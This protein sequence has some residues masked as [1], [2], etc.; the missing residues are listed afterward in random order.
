MKKTLEKGN[1]YDMWIQSGR[2]K[3]IKHCFYPGCKS[4]RII[5]SHVFQNNG[6]LT[7][8]SENGDV[9]MPKQKNGDVI[10]KLVK[11]GRKMATVFPGFCNEH[12]KKVF[13]PIEDAD[14]KITP[15]TVF[16]FSY[17]T[18]ASQFQA[19]MEF[20][21]RFN[22]LSD[23]LG[24]TTNID[25]LDGFKSSINDFNHDKKFFD[26]YLLNGK[27]PPL[28]YISWVIRQ[29]I[30]FAVSGFNAPYADFE[31]KKIQNSTDKI[32]HHMFYTILPYKGNCV[33]LISWLKTDDRMF[34]SY[35]N[36]LRHLTLLERK[37][38]LSNMAISISDDL[39]LSP[40]LVEQL[41]T[42]QI[43]QI[44]GDYGSIG[45]LSEIMSER[46]SSAHQL[47]N[48]GLNLFDY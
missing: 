16:L 32:N 29:P 8:I 30:K 40:S 15:A 22:I 46:A 39:V 10:T 13:Q 20:V 26:D 42:M 35:T 5:K 27:R 2:K 1:F 31:G 24:T 41:N 33:A 44:E 21:N 45:M 12:D 7:T 25:F 38:Y 6:V 47:D 48:I 34:K 11:F 23:D 17:R 18:F 14:W 19:K 37:Q 43:Q 4:E 3:Y 9:F 36:T 28:N